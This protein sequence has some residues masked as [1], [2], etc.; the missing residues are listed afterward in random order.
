MTEIVASIQPLTD[1]I[2]EMITASTDHS[3]GVTQ[4]G[5]FVSQIDH[6]TQRSVALL[7]DSAVAAECLNNLAQKLVAVAVA[8]F[9]IAQGHNQGPVEPVGGV[10]T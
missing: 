10:H 3:S 1:I 7:K 5:Q 6:A 2:G 9:R 4:M 8:A